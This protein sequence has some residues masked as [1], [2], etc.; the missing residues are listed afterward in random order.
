[1]LINGVK[2]FNTILLGIKDFDTIIKIP[3]P[4]DRL[5]DFKVIFIDEAFYKCLRI[6]LFHHRLI[7]VGP[8]YLV[9]AIPRW[10]LQLP[11]RLRSPRTK[12]ILLPISLLLWSTSRDLG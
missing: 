6:V 8:L 1:M 5:N 7:V 3:I 2:D 11:R 10:F 4:F 9:V 12:Y